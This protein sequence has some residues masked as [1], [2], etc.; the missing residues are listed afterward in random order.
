ML[1]LLSVSSRASQLGEFKGLILLIGNWENTIE[2]SIVVTIFKIFTVGY[3][4]FLQI[5]TL[6]HYWKCLCQPLFVFS[7]RWWENSIP[8]KNCWVSSMNIKEWWLY[9]KDSDLQVFCF[10]PKGLETFQLILNVVRPVQHPWTCGSPST[11]CSCWG[12][13]LLNNSWF[14]N[15]KIVLN[16]KQHW[17]L[18]STKWDELHNFC[19]RDSVE[20]TFEASID[21]FFLFFFFF[22][23]RRGFQSSL[24]PCLFSWSTHAI[25]WSTVK[26]KNQI[27]LKNDKGLI[28]KYYFKNWIQISKTAFKIYLHLPLHFFIVWNC[29]SEASVQI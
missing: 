22:S 26:Y 6:D 27:V 29:D 9:L 5:S 20:V 13:W 14:I 3:L 7:K 28:E 23:K 11:S 15:K 4:R 2:H 19:D 10:E 8:T 17:F 24:K 12:T 21:E 25:P 18:Q 16:H 1:F